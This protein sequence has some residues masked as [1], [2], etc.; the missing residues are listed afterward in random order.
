MTAACAGTPAC[1]GQ[2]K[3]LSLKAMAAE[4][5]A[6][7]FGPATT[8]GGAPE[9]S[10]W[11]EDKI[12]GCVCDST[13]PVGFGAAETQATQWF[14]TDCARKRCPSGNDP[15]TPE[16]ETDCAWRA[17]NGAT[18]MGDVG[19]DGVQYAP[20]AAL[21]PGV[22]VATLATG[23]QGVTAGAAGNK[24]YVECASRGTCDF[25]TGTCACFA[26]YGGAACDMLRRG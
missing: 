7:P 1:S 26:G 15:M 3:C 23:V 22:T 19:S 6:A 2:G 21:P 5:N 17:D 20:G 11:D 9:T 12:F 14:G 10:T 8:Y 24:C 13:W 16:D 25:A 18:W 4:P